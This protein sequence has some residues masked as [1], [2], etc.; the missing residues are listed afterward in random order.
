MKAIFL[1][2]L[3]LIIGGVMSISVNSSLNG[4]FAQL[5]K[6][7][8]NPPDFIFA[9][10]WTLLYI[11]LAV[12]YWLIDRQQY[13][14]QT[15]EIKR[16]FVWQLILNFL[17]TPVFFG[18]RNILA[19]LIVLLIIDFLVFRIIRLTY[20]VNKVFVLIILPYF[21]WLLFATYL[22]VSIFLIN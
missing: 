1:A 11:S 17:W 18:M 4:W 6:P 12:F 19:G 20:R 8:L 16:L 14:P 5:N 22:N 3:F 7:P 10:V 2:V 15:A 13:S 9:P 21:C